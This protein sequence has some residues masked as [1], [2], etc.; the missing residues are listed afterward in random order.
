MVCRVPRAC[1]VCHD[2]LMVLGDGIVGKPGKD[3]WE[4]GDLMA[5]GGRGG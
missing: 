2:G 4:L 3:K 5:E 1:G